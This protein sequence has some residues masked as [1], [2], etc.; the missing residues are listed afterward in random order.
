MTARALARARLWLEGA[1]PRTL[2]ASVTPV[3]VGT[4]AAARPSAVKALAALTVAVALQVGVNYANDYSDGVRR[5][6]TPKRVG[7]VRLVASG[8]A[9]ASSVRTAALLAFAV[10]A[11]VGLWLAVSTDLRLLAFGALALAGAVLYSGGPRPY[12]ELGLGE[13]AVFLFFG[14]FATC[15]T[16]Y[17]QGRTVP[18]AAWVAAA[19][20]G[21]FSAA[22]LV[23]NNLRDISTDAEA[24]KRTVAVRVGDTKTRMLYA[25]LIITGFAAPVAGVVTGAV[26]LLAL[27]G[28]AAAAL[29]IRALVLMRT[30]TGREL[31]RVLLLTSLMQV[32]FGALFAIGLAVA[33]A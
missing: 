17:V 6:D 1:R 10:A 5:V 7:P 14:L 19:S 29:A 8:L 28:L 3:I 12:A 11:G 2:S 21:A 30:G 32:V 31:I 20:V 15:G 9:S 18:A 25:A 13:V 23:A 4:A 22:I 26:P 16:A 27:L 33:R 24:G